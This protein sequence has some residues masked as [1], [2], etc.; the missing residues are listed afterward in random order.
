M[1][2]APVLPHNSS[3]NNRTLY[4]FLREATLCVH[5]E[6]LGFHGC[7]LC[8]P[9]SLFQYW[10]LPADS[11]NNVRETRRGLSLNGRT[12]PIT[13]L[14]HAIAGLSASGLGITVRVH[15][16]DCVCSSV[17]VCVCV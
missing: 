12:Q 9:W 6:R 7:V 1:A 11:I 3:S 10:P 5:V 4:A 2:Q 15:V 16:C 8:V 14:D 13:D 17:C